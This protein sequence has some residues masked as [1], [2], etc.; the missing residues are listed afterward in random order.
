MSR[1]IIYIIVIFL[2]ASCRKPYPA[3]EEQK[4]LFYFKGKINGQTNELSAG[5]A[6][7]YLFTGYQNALAASDNFFRFTGTLA[8]T[9]CN[10]CAS[11]T[12]EIND[13]SI[14]PDTYVPA[15]NDVLITGNYDYL[16]I[17]PVSQNLQYQ[18]KAAP[19][20]DSYLWTFGD[21]TT[22]NTQNPIHIF[23]TNS[24]FDVCLKATDTINGCSYT[25]CN[26]INTNQS[27]DY[28]LTFDYELQQNNIYFTP[29]TSGWTPISWTLNDSLI[30]TG[31]LASTNF[32]P[33]NATA[34]KVCFTA[35]KNNIT[36]TFCRVLKLQGIATCSADWL[37]TSVV[38]TNSISDAF[39]K[40]R[41]VYRTNDGKVYSSDKQTQDASSFFYINKV[42]DY[43]L[44]EMGYKT[45]KVACT[46]RA[47]LFNTVNANDQLIIESNDCSWGLSYP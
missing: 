10:T 13:A 1:V 46:Y 17:N 20:Y 16:N 34:Y 31:L 4:P 14:R 45:K 19:G 37:Y 8:S 9:S 44:N 18:F 5:V 42:E 21:G 22:A 35:S 39:S 33:V 38:D 40:V 6:D 24:S 29:T 11:L 47:I 3:L 27:P 26:E 32:S 23:P 41:I 15:I 2:F 36:K 28:D 7:Y 25:S 12:I 30:S 43:L